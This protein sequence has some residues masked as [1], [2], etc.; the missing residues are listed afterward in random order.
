MSNMIQ[1]DHAAS[2]YNDKRQTCA[3]CGLPHTGDHRCA[4]QPAPTAAPTQSAR[5]WVQTI[6]HLECYDEYW[7]TEERALE[8]ADR[9]DTAE[10][11]LAE[12]EKQLTL[13]GERAVVDWDNETVREVDAAVKGSSKYNDWLRHVLTDVPAKLAAAQAD[14]Q[15]IKEIRQWFAKHGWAAGPE[16]LDRIVAELAAAQ[17]EARKRHEEYA[18]T[19]NKRVDVENALLAVATGKRELLTREECRALAYKLGQPVQ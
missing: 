18:K 8:L 19:L 6:R 5:E 12:A 2:F 9:A 13:I 17:D 3:D 15:I 4:E 7:I 10:A 1:I 14:Q 16:P 11:K